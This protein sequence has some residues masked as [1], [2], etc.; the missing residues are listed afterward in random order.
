VS[1]VPR[2]VEELKVA[3]TTAGRR[4]DAVGRD[5]DPEARRDEDAVLVRLLD[6][7]RAVVTIRGRGSDRK[8]TTFPDEAAAVAHVAADLL[9]PPPPV[10]EVR[11]EDQR[12]A[13]VTRAEQRT[14]EAMADLDRL[15]AADEG[16]RR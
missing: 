13:D 9:A 5:D 12:R 14:R 3:L 10:A 1:P 16:G 7:G 8:Q 11:T 2:T 15:R 4:S 6:D